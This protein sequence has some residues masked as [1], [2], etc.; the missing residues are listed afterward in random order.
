MD[1]FDISEKVNYLIKSLNYKNNKIV[2]LI[3]D[4][5]NI[6][7]E[8]E[9]IFKKPLLN[10]YE[11]NN[12]IYYD[13]FI[14]KDP[15]LSGCYLYSKFYDKLLLNKKEKNEIKIIT[16]KF[17]KKIITFLKNNNYVNFYEL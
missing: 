15:N 14:I 9:I 5:L 16:K 7:N 13:E 6:L 2:S 11:I 8:L 12:I 3:D 17:V 4:V 1:N 10:F